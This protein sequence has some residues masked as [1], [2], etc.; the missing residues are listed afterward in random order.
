MKVLYYILIVI[1][2]ILSIFIIIYFVNLDKDNNDYY[3][4]DNDKNLSF[5]IDAV[6]AWVDGNDIDW[7]K[8]RDKYSKQAT[9]KSNKD[10]RFVNINEIYY[11][12]LGI[13]KYLPW[14]NNIFLVTARPQ[15][16]AFL[17]K[18]FPMVKVI[19]HDQIY[20][21]VSIL[22]VFNSSSIETQLHNIPGLSENFIYFNDDFY[23]GKPLNKSFFF[24][25]YGRPIHYKRHYL[26]NDIKRT[27]KLLKTSSKYA[28]LHQAIP[29][30]KKILSN[31][32]IRYPN[33]LDYTSRSRFRNSKDILIMGI[34]HR[35]NDVVKR[36]LPN[37]EQLYKN[38]I[39]DKNYKQIRKYIK[40]KISPSLI[41]LNNL[42]VS[43]KTHVKLFNKF[44]ERYLRD[45]RKH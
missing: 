11:C 36:K 8:Q 2:V 28:M 27:Y 35:S 25:E 42:K 29:L 7:N 5:P 1:I 23:I 18:E 14:I 21:D 32:W 43:N 9:K 19:H 39:A 26:N 16:P 30:T 17:R 34:A 10:V 3:L 6:I 13:V 15:V 22:P 24:E 37:Y 4:K 20:K 38:M 33:E 41:C 44:K 12:L 31:A 45:L 40:N